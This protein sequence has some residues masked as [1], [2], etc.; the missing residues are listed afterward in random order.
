MVVLQVGET[1]GFT[2]KVEG[3]NAVAAYEAAVERLAADG[4]IDSDNLGII[5]FSRT[6][7]HVIQAMTASKLHFKAASI[8]EG[9]NEGYYQ[10]ASL[11]DFAGNL[12]LRDEETINGGIPIG[13]NLEQWANRSPMFNLDKVRTPLLVVATNPSSIP[14][15]WEPYAI[16]R[17]L[18]QPVELVMLN[19]GMHVLTNPAERMV[20][21]G[22]N[23]DWLRFWLQGYEDNDPRKAAQYLRWREMRDKWEK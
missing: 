8:T 11:I 21:Q 13:T 3:T 9:A 4:V 5:G 16:L 1:P 23:V 14:I 2:S 18:K 22:G 20:S 12:Y 17:R 6:C 15:V 19:H 10:Y 7:Y